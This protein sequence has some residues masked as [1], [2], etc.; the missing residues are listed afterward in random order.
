[1]HLFLLPFK[2]FRD[3]VYLCWLKLRRTAEPWMSRASS[4]MAQSDLLFQEKNEVWVRSM[5]AKRGAARECRTHWQTQLYQVVFSSFPTLMIL[6]LHGV[7]SDNNSPVVLWP[8]LYWETSPTGHFWAE[9]SLYIYTH[10]RV[11]DTSKVPWRQLSD[12]WDITINEGKWRCW[13]R[14]TPI[15][16]GKWNGRHK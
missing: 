12:K 9:C 13:L 14:L 15:L 10:I 3:A 4:G 7:L 8:F 2:L 16:Q 1:M 5:S 11:T 6:M